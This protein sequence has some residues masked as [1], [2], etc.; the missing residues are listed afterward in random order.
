CGAHTHPPDHDAAYAV[1][2]GAP[3]PRFVH[4]PVVDGIA[5]E[6]GQI[7]L[8]AVHTPGHTP[9]H[10]SYVLEENGVVVAVFPGGAML[11]GAGGRTDLADPRL[12]RSA[13]HDQWRSV[14]WL[15]SRLP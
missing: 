9:H 6:I 12:A 8:R 13:A 10:M 4:E 3:A 7:I 11:A 15:A 1:P 2:G 14:R 5:V